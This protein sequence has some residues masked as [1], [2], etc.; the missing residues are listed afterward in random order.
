M[1]QEIYVYVDI[2][3]SSPLK[4]E[5]AL[6]IWTPSVNEWWR[7]GR[8]VRDGQQEG[9]FCGRVIQQP[10]F[11]MAIRLGSMEEISVDK[12]STLN[13]R[14]CS[15]GGRVRQEKLHTMIPVFRS[16]RLLGIEQFWTNY[17][18]SLDIL[19]RPPLLANNILN[20]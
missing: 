19:P 9:D 5:N 18:S 2:T 8:S 11:Y 15:T 10:T 6:S 1:N 3:D 7:E 20:L 17:N 14:Y 13:M 12:Q 4:N 16:A